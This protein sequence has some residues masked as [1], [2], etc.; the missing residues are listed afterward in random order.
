V[1]WH[2][3]GPGPALAYPRRHHN[4]S[5]LTRWA[6]QTTVAAWGRPAVCIG[7]GTDP[8][9]ETPGS[10]ALDLLPPPRCLCPRTPVFRPQKGYTL[11]GWVPSG[12]PAILAFI[13]RFNRRPTQTFGR[14]S[15]QRQQFAT[16][17]RSQLFRARSANAQRDM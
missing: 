3:E 4:A 10:H 8:A 9:V 15:L 1:P 6:D 12:W 7:G 11:P 16:L 17:F 14:P 2:A 13:A 5:L